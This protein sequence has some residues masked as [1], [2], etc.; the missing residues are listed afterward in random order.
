MALPPGCVRYT[1]AF[2]AHGLDIK[3]DEVLTVI[4]GTQAAYFGVKPQWKLLMIDGEEMVDETLIRPCLMRKSKSGKKYQIVFSKTAEEMRADIAAQEAAEAA[5]RERL[6][7]EER[8]RKA[9]EAEKAAAEAAHK[10]E[11]DGKKAAFAESQAAAAKPAST[12]PP[13]G[14]NITVTRAEGAEAP[15]DVGDNDVIIKYVNYAEPFALNADGAL[16][17]ADIDAVYSLSTVMPGCFLHLS[18]REFAHDE[19]HLYIKEEPQGVWPSLTPKMTYCLYVQ[20]DKAQYEA[21]MARMKDVWCKAATGELPTLKEGCSCLYGA[22]C[23]NPDN[24]KDWDNRFAVA[25]ANG[26]NPNLFQ[27]A[28]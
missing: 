4:D 22:P 5:K 27:N 12:K 9:A 1:F 24:C 3:G 21:D 10:A 16:T 6:A 19:E 14:V 2:G 13:E 23:V 20:Q 26:G 15:R 7:Q 11:I 28:A 25:K 17:Q 8:E 18:V